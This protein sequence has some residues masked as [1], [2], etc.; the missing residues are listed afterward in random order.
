[1][2]HYIP[3]DSIQRAAPPTTA[4][5]RAIDFGRLIPG[6]FIKT[7]LMGHEFW[8]EVQRVMGNELNATVRHV[9]ETSDQLNPDARQWVGRT[10][11]LTEG[12]ILDTGCDH[13]C[14]C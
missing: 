6:C 13:F 1:M 12:D 3:V 9:A 5:S 8:A 7:Q 14:W 10:V 2:Q 4:A 11:T